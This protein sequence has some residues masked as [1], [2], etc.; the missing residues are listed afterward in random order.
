M[1]IRVLQVPLS[2]RLAVV[3]L[4]VINGA[5]CALGLYGV[6]RWIRNP[7]R[8]TW[9]NVYIVLTLVEA[10]ARGGWSPRR[11]GRPV[12]WVRRWALWRHFRRYFDMTVVYDGKKEDLAAAKPVVL[13]GHPHGVIGV[14]LVGNAVFENGLLPESMPYRIM[15][16]EPL[17]YIPLM[18]DWCQ[19]LN[20]ASV[21]ESSV[22]YCL[23]N[24]ISTVIVVGGVEEAL[25]SRP[26]TLRLTLASRSGFIKMALK[27]GA[28]L[29]PLL[30]FGETDIYKQIVPNPQ[31]SFLRRVQT[32]LKQWAGFSVPVVEL[33]NPR[34]VKVTTVV[35]SPIPVPKVP[36]P[37]RTDVEK[38]RAVYIGE[39]KRLY[40]K[41]S[42]TAYPVP[43]EPL[44][45]V[46]AKL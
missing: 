43:H 46:D 7:R 44:R 17:F 27:H 2:A 40:A 23:R 39:V 37:T 13:G 3:A 24:G 25:D 8:A 12:G 28:P 18:G 5:L 30:S 34:P 41:F 42:P 15:A 4:H 6:A 9:A 1:A 21:H 35:G 16:T 14:A 10:V 31:G 20:L 29:V 11:A 38:W 26:N 36:N 22:D 33:Y 32:A 19:A 45:I